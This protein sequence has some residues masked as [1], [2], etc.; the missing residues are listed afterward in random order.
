MA[1]IPTDR[2]FI[3][4]GRTQEDAARHTFGVPFPAV[5]SGVFQTEY[6]VDEARDGTGALNFT[7][8]S[9]DIN[10]I[11]IEWNCIE[12]EEWW[13]LNNWIATNGRVFWVEYFNHMLGDWDVKQFYLGHRSVGPVMIDPETGIPDHYESARWNIRDMGIVQ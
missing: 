11:D 8:T 3:Y 13:R 10:G 6:F 4:I 7:V 9:R 2:R 5:N 12:C 1:R